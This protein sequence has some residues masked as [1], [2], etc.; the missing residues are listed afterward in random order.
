[1]HRV[2]HRVDLSER[3]S[4]NERLTRTLPASTNSKASG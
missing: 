4:F 3:M 1:M 2:K